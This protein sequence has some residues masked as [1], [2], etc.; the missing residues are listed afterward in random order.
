MRVVELV[1]MVDGLAAAGISLVVVFDRCKAA[2]TVVMVVEV[3]VAEV[4]L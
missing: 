3:V 2:L 4:P 1:M